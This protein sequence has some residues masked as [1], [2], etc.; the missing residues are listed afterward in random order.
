MKLKMESEKL[1]MENTGLGASFLSI[2]HSPLSILNS[3]D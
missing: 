1:K 2:F 3:Y